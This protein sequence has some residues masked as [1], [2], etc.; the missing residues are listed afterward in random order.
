MT[1]QP[2]DRQEYWR[3]IIDVRRIGWF[4]LAAVL[5]IVP[6]AAVL[7]LLTGLVVYG[8]FPVL[9]TAIGFLRQPFLLLPFALSTLVFGPLPE[10]IGWR[11]FALDR[12]QHKLNP[13]SASLVL[14]VLWVI[15]F[16]K[17]QSCFTV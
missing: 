4:W 3:R 9:P 14:G 1:N 13:L 11:G 15:T 8:D 17:I 2:S 10:E 5:L 16:Y 7:A 12:L 6:L